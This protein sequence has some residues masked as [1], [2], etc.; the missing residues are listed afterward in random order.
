M[1][2]HDVSTAAEAGL[3]AVTN[4]YLL[5]AAEGRFDVLVTTD[6]NIRYQQNL[7]GRSVAIV[8]LMSTNWPMIR[9][10]VG[11]VRSAVDGVGPGGYSEVTFPRPPKPPRKP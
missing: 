8:V 2:G 4:G 7:T 5:K 11:N 10:H 9:L 3:G 6:Q 1:T